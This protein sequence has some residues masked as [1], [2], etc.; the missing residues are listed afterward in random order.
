[1][2]SLKPG[3]EL[4]INGNNLDHP[5]LERTLKILRNRG[6]ITNMTVNQVHFIKYYK[7]L[8]TIVKTPALENVNS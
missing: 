2:L 8:P 3:T 4:A 7:K 1:M 6:I 5:H